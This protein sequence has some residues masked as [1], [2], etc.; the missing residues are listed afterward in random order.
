MDVKYT[1]KKLEKS[2]SDD[3]IIKKEYGRLADR[4][5]SV[6][7]EL[8]VADTLDD[9]PTVPPDRRHKMTNVDYTWSIDLSK[10]YRMWVKSDG[11]DDPRLV[12]SVEIVKIFDDH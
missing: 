11:I 1:N 9:I 12:T 4:I 5:I 10:N 6:L 2:L 3:R 7:S 8:E